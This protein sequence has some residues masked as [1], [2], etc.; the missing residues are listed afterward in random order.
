MLLAKS[1]R[2]ILCESTSG[3]FRRTTCR[4]NGMEFE[5]FHLPVGEY[6]HEGAACELQAAFPKAHQ[7]HAKAGDGGGSGALVCGSG[8]TALDADCRS[9]SISLKGTRV[10]SDTERAHDHLMV[11][12]A[13]GR[14]RHSRPCHVG[15][16]GDKQ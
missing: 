4:E 3:G 12:K 9:T 1:G 13:L 11:D 6:F 5:R 14:V 10:Q 16:R 7:C 15:R 2:Q 8:Q